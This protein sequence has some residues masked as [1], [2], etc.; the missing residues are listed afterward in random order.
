MLPAI[1]RVHAHSP[2][3]RTGASSSHLRMIRVYRNHTWCVCVAAEDDMPS[4]SLAQPTTASDPWRHAAASAA[5]QAGCYVVK[6]NTT[7]FNN[8]T[9]FHALCCSWHGRQAC[10]MGDT[11][12]HEPDC[13]RR[14]SACHLFSWA[15]QAHQSSTEVGCMHSRRTSH[16]SFRSEG[17]NRL[18]HDMAQH[19]NGLATCMWLH[20]PPVLA[21]MGSSCMPCK[22]VL[23]PRPPCWGTGLFAWGFT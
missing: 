19:A 13:F 1:A 4:G 5:M 6:G 2:L 15:A 12:A 7:H 11:H 9:R 23:C 21:D 18:Q 14:Q 20:V 3:A 8:F 10:G 16:R 22:P 17:T